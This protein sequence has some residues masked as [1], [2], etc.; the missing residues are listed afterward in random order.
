MGEKPSHSS[1]QFPETDHEILFEEVRPPLSFHMANPAHREE[2]A[3]RVAQGEPIGIFVVQYGVV[4]SAEDEATTNKLLTQVKGPHRTSPIPIWIQHPRE[5]VAADIVDFT[6]IHPDL[7]YLFQDPSE[8]ADRTQGLCMVK[9]PIKPDSALNGTPLHSLVSDEDETGKWL[10]FFHAGRAFPHAQKFI[11]RIYDGGIQLVGISSLNVHGG[12][13]PTS[14]E[15]A[16]AFCEVRNVSSFIVDRGSR[17]TERR[18][19][20]P[21][22]QITHEGAMLR[23]LGNVPVRYL[24]AAGWRITGDDSAVPQPTI[25]P[26]ERRD[27]E[28]E[29]RTFSLIWEEFPELSNLII[30]TDHSSSQLKK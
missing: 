14:L 5:I 11:E 24:E 10:L 18:G 25:P 3:F 16:I 15:E 28:T 9:F 17:F 1:E 8:L 7:H 19:S 27:F 22:I 6:R 30:Q 21:I 2:V 23:R 13:S 29:M 20:Y 12:V 26:S 4:F